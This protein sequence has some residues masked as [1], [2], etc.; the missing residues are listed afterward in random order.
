[1]QYVQTGQLPNG[2]ADKKIY[3]NMKDLWTELG[4]VD[5]SKIEIIANNIILDNATTTLPA[6]ETF[7]NIPAGSP[8]HTLK[9]KDPINPATWK[10]NGLITVDFGNW[11]TK[12]VIVNTTI[13]SVATIAAKWPEKKKR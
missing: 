5:V 7:I 1:M 8:A 4:K 6:I 9:W 2:Y 3:E 13:N 11:I 10:T 12:D